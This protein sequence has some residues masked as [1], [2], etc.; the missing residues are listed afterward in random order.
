M[1][2]LKKLICNVKLRYLAV[3][4]CGFSFDF[5]I[6]LILLKFKVPVYLA[7]LVAFLFGSIANVILI[8]TFIF[9]DNRFSLAQDVLMTFAANGLVISIGTIVLWILVDL[10]YANPYTSKLSVGVATFLVNYFIRAF[11]FRRR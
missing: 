4:C 3:A 8:R 11:F 6:Y 5:I 9:T 2:W 1:L 7:N 10:F